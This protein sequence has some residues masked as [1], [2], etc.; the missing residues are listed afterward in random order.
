M[1]ID[2][3][4]K[5]WAVDAVIDATDISR[6]SIYVSI[7]QSKYLGYLSD[8]KIELRKATKEYLRLRKDKTRYYRGEM[9]MEELKQRGW[10]QYLGPKLLK[11]D[12]AD[13]VESDDDI[14]KITDRVEYISIVIAHLEGIM[15]S[16]FSRGYDIKNHIA[17]EQ[18]KGGK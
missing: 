4:K 16:L 18:W 15:R 9:T 8:H 11:A 5:Q 7:L 6:E 2:D 1:L 17:W 13:A 3:L 10:A 14:I 12:V